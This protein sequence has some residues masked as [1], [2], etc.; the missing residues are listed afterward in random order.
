MLLS[1]LPQPSA[2]GLF[3]EQTMRLARVGEASFGAGD[4]RDFHHFKWAIYPKWVCGVD[5][6]SSVREAP[7][8]HQYSPGEYSL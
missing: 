5:E 2:A 1:I 4:Y 7:P 3:V 8:G 6:L